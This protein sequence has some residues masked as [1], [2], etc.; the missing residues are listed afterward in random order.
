[1]SG[2]VADAIPTMSSKTKVMPMKKKREG[3]NLVPAALTV[4]V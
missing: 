4:D 2:V 1:L 3:L